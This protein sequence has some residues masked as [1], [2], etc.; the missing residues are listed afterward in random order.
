MPGRPCYLLSRPA[1]FR[2]PKT[3]YSVYLFGL[4]GIITLEPLTLSA[5]NRLF[6][7]L[8]GF[9]PIHSALALLLYSLLGL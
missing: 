3:D 6:L 1:K 9:N 8:L 5:W 2:I 7:F 4:D